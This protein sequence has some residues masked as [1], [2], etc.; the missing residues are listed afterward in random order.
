MSSEGSPASARTHGAN[1]ARGVEGRVAMVTGGAA[2]L[3]RAIAAELAAIGAR[4]AIADVDLDTAETVAGELRDRGL[5]ALAVECDVADRASVAS[6]VDQIGSGLGSIGILVNNAGLYDG[7]T[8]EFGVL[9]AGGIEHLFAVNVFALVHCTLACAEHMRALGGG[10]VVNIASDAGYHSRSPYGVTKL[11]VRGL[12]I[13]LATELA[14]DGIRVNGIAP[15]LIATDHA[16]AH[17]ARDDVA[18]R[19]SRRQLIPR[20]GREPD[21]ADAVVFLVSEQS[22]FVTGETI[23]VNGGVDLFI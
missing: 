12:T 14:G 8:R 21:V 20:L 17:V 7:Y 5:I 16:L 18:D 2:G 10:S 11:T 15:G 23:R 22:A 9:D 3:G 6:A 19:V 13:A 1:R 4:V